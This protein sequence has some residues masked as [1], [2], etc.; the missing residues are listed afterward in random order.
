MTDL[1]ISNLN[2]PKRM[3]EILTI[4]DGGERDR[5]AAIW[6]CEY[7]FDEL[8]PK[9]EPIKPEKVREYLAL[10]PKDRQKMNTDPSRYDH[11]WRDDEVYR[12]FS[13]R[14]R[15]KAE[16]QNN[17]DWLKELLGYLSLQD[18][19]EIKMIQERLKEWEFKITPEQ[20][21][22]RDIFKGKVVQRADWDEKET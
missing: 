2:C 19:K 10:P 12:Y 9:Q 6:A 20:E 17:K 11:F 14:H 7:G 5:Q 4:E 15:I 18:T 13:E 21:T 3:K 1:T 8:R 16:N 22:I